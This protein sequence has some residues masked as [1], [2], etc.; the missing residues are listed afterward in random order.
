M[1][2][3]RSEL[4]AT[5]ARK[6]QHK[7][8]KEAAQRAAKGELDKQKANSPVDPDLLQLTNAFVDRQEARHKADYDLNEPFAKLQASRWIQNAG[9]AL[10]ALTRVRLSESGER[11][12]WEMLLGKLE[13]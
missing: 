11:L 4:R 7:L 2:P 12:F 1:I 8:M 3:A 9:L 13:R 5:V 10:A 6:F